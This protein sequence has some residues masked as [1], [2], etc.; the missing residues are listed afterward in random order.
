MMMVVMV[1]RTM[2]TSSSSSDDD[3]VNDTILPSPH[4]RRAP[5]GVIRR[6]RH[7]Q[8]PIGAASNESQ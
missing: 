7:R 2:A 3:H 4:L 5:V 8:R 1:M 6:M